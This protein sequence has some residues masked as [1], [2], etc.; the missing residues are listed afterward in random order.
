MIWI[1]RRLTLPPHSQG[2]FAITSE[3]VHALPEIEQVKIGLVN[4]FL[5]H[6]SAGLTINENADP[7]VLTDLEGRL[8]EL[9]PVSSKYEHELEGEDDMPGHIKSSLIGVTLTVPVEEGHLL[10]GTWQDI[11]LCEYREALHRRT[12]ILT[13]NGSNE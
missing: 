11:Y 10:L 9:A 6:T 2:I 13:L 7:S 8:S 12:V 5:Q 1:R 4:L 3:V